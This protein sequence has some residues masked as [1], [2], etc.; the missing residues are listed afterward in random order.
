MF[1]WTTNV[2]NSISAELKLGFNLFDLDFL[3][4]LLISFIRGLQHRLYK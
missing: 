4:I 2:N 1:F 3:G